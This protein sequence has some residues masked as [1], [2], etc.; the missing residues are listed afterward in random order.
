MMGW[1][2]S[3]CVMKGMCVV[4]EEGLGVTCRFVAVL[5]CLVGMVGFRIVGGE[6]RIVWMHSIT[7]SSSSVARGVAWSMLFFRCIVAAMMWPEGVGVGRR[8]M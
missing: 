2:S 6:W 5:G 8:F 4:I 3:S 7:E 1:S